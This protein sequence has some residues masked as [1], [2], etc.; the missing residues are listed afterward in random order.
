MFNFCKFKKRTKQKILLKPQLDPTEFLYII[1]LH[2]RYFELTQHIKRFRTLRSLFPD[3]VKIIVVYADPEPNFSFDGFDI[4]II[5]P[6]PL[7][8]YEG[9]RGTSYGESANIRA[10]LEYAYH[11]FPNASGAIVS[12]ADSWA[13]KPLVEYFLQCWRG[14]Y[15]AST[16]GGGSNGLMYITNTFFINPRRRNYWPPLLREDC[17]ETLEW[18]WGREVREKQ[19]DRFNFYYPRPG[20]DFFTSHD[21]RTQVEWLRNNKL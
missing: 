8:S 7:L 13:S 3:R 5:L 18:E 9:E 10:A 15:G 17:P 19:L 2:R 11:N 6:R 14:D 1:T 4:D 20:F 21:F 12:A 16:T